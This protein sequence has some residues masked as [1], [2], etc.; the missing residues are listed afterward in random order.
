M[1]SP[2]A[3]KLHHVL[4]DLT[5]TDSLFC[6]VIELPKPAIRTPSHSMVVS[7]RRRAPG[8][9]HHRPQIH[10]TQALKIQ[11]NFRS[12]ASAPKP[13]LPGSGAQNPQNQDVGLPSNATLLRKG[14]RQATA[15]K[16]ER[17]SIVSPAQ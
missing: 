12:H 13:S 16:A 17:I 1:H 5:V 7:T 9:V 2:L 11:T 14:L 15:A 3:L 10:A 4:T 6:P 8:M